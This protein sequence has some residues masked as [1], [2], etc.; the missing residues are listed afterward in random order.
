M[1][2][3]A[4]HCANKFLNAE[5]KNKILAEVVT[6]ANKVEVKSD[7]KTMEDFAKKYTF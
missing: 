3:R 7:I 6:E 5:A 1:E 2:L 4:V